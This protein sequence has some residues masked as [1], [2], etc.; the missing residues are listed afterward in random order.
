MPK[1]KRDYSSCESNFS[2]C[3]PVKSRQKIPRISYDQEPITSC[4]D[5]VQPQNPASNSKGKQ[6]RSFVKQIRKRLDKWY[7]ATKTP[8]CVIYLRGGTVLCEGP[9]F[10]KARFGRNVDIQRKFLLAVLNHGNNVQSEEEI[11]S[12]NVNG[13]AHFP[14]S[15]PPEGGNYKVEDLRK[16]VTSCVTIGKSGYCNPYWGNAEY[17]PC[18]WPQEI[19]FASP[20]TGKSRLSK[21]HLVR[22][23]ECYR[24][25][26]SSKT[27][28]GPHIVPAQQVSSG[29]EETTTQE[30]GQEPDSN[31][32]SLE[33]IS[34]QN[35]NAQAH[36]P[37]SLPP[38]GG[39]CKVDDL[40][41]MVTKCVTIG[42]NGGYCS[43]HWGKAEYRPCWWPQEIP[44]VSPYAGRS[45][46]SKTQLVRVMECYRS[47]YPSKTTSSTHS[48][49]PQQVNSRNE[50]TITQEAG[51]QPAPHNIIYIVFPQVNNSSNVQTVTPEDAGQRSDADIVPPLQETNDKPE[52]LT[53]EDGQS[54]VLYA[55]QGA[56]GATTS[57]LT[58]KD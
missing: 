40:R 58:E 35:M 23:M 4:Y 31:D 49:P 42:K 5:T 50:E 47:F 2:N 6:N 32:Q 28:S 14:V 1:K 10:L 27:S 43:P 44:F 36:F 20:C 41:K 30:D 45:R 48:V 52:I 24:S 9:E 13:E 29:D 8:A 12:E 18:W 39:N 34:S 51:Q 46:L 25:F 19:P 56:V 21:M 55:L 57:I 37:V 22:V 38:E 26:Y 53:Q 3:K 54:E 17:R 7:S 16:I 33:E 11:S 15:L